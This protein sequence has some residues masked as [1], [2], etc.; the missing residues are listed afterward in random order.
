MTSTKTHIPGIVLTDDNSRSLGVGQPIREGVYWR[1][2][3]S[4]HPDCWLP[5]TPQDEWFGKEV[6]DE[7]GM[8]FRVPFHIPTEDVASRYGITTEMGKK[9]LEIAIKNIQLLD[10]KQ[11]DYGSQNIAA[12]G[13]FGVL[14]RAW[15]KVSRLRNLLGNVQSPANESIEDSWLDLS[16]YAIIAALCRRGEW[17]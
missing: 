17:K 10:S 16:N 13:E 8:F 15:D 4:T 7:M 9:A 2:E 14:V 5:V 6:N 12:F 1:A 11:K 3:A